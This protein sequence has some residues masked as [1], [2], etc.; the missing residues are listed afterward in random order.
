MNY[1]VIGFGKFGR[2]A[3]DRLL[4]EDPESAIVIVEQN[5]DQIDGTVAPH[6]KTLVRDGIS[7]LMDS[8]QIEQED[9]VVPM[10]PF[11]LA[12]SFILSSTPGCR[13]IPFPEE[14][15]TLVPNPF[16]IDRSNLC[17]SKA[18]FMCPDDCPEGDLCTVTGMP[19]EPLYHELESLKIREFTILVR[20]SFQILPGVGGYRYR[21]LCRMKEQCTPGKYLIAT[22]CKCHAMLTAL[23]V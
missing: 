9:I 4:N 14:L 5:K 20:R 2:L 13:A 11:H 8:A 17:C 21:D 15:E 6:V 23:Q 12:A 7:F 22:S 3:V 1:L 19:R 18:D 10:V 16:P